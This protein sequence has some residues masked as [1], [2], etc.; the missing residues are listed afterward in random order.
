MSAGGAHL[1]TI[2]A[3]AV[4][5]GVVPGVVVLASAAGRI[6]L[7]EVAGHSQIQSTSRLTH[8]HTVWDLAS[9]TKPLVTSVLAM[10]AIAEGALRLDDPIGVEPEGATP[11]IANAMTVRLAL[12]HAAGLT[13]HLP[14]WSHVLGPD[15]QGA[16]SP[17]ARAA[18]IAA[19]GRAPLAYLPA[20]R[21]I[22]SD[23]GFIL[24]GDLLERRLGDRLDRLAAAR[25]GPPYGT[26]ALSFRPVSPEAKAGAPQVPAP[27]DP[28]ADVADSQ[29]CPL[30]KRLLRG[31]VDDLNAYAMGG[32]AGH[33]GLFGTVDAVAAV[34]HALLAAYR[35]AGVAGTSPLVDGEVV[36][37]FWTPAGIPGSTWR[38]GW[39]GP[40]EQGSQAG[41]RI[42]RTAVGHLAF[43]GCS[44]WIDPARETFVVMLS[45]RVNPP[46]HPRFR[47]L[48]RAANDAALDAVGYR[49]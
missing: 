21:S 16:G 34:V 36:R 8:R 23:L 32:V 31:E 11:A 49:A 30:R 14:F 2:L 22:Y 44:L 15:G 10:H 46:A 26:A 38:L 5:E 9:L 37:Q 17:S 24:L 25:L 20:S 18:V 29:L 1:R 47:D 28:S 12:A 13:A 19:A 35:G 27:E 43:T 4:Q 45:N 3:T 48:R 40:S 33:A 42:A 39:D 6:G 41:D 7:C